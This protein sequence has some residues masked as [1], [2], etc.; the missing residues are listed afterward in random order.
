MVDEPIEI[1]V[2]GDTVG[3]RGSGA[4]RGA[5]R[6]VRAGDGH[7]A[8]H[9][10]APPSPTSSR[11][12]W[13]TTA[14]LTFVTLAEWE[15]DAVHLSHHHLKIG[16]DATVKHIS[17]TFGGDLVRIERVRGYDGP[18][19]DLDLLGLYSPTSGQHLEHRLFVDHAVPHCKSRALY[20]G[21]LQGRK[22]H[23]VW[24]GDVLIRTAAEGTDTYEMNRNLVLTEGARADSVPNLEIE[25]GEIVG[26][27]HASATGK[28][29]RRAA[30]LPAVPGHPAE[31]AKRLVVR[32]FFG[33]VLLRIG[34]PRWSSGPPRSSNG[35]SPSPACRRSGIHRPAPCPRTEGAARPTRSLDQDRSVGTYWSRKTWRHWI[36]ATCTSRSLT[37]EAPVEILRGVDLTVSSNETHAIMGPN[38]SGK[39]TL[40]YS[41]AGH[42]K[43]KVTRGSV[44][45][46]GQDLLAMT[47][48]E[49]ARAGL[50]LAMQ[51]PVEVP[52]VSTS[53]F[54]RTAAT[55]VRGQAPAIRTWVKEVK[56]AMNDLEID[57]EFAE[58]SVNEGFSGG[59]KKRHEILQ[60]TLLRPK[61]AILDETD[62]GLDVDALRVV[63]EG[64]NRYKAS[65]AEGGEGVGIMLITHY[66][67]ILRY[68]HP[69]RV[70][71]FAGGRIVE[72][73]GPELADELET[74]G[75]VR[76][77]GTPVARRLIP[78][79]TPAAP[80]RPETR[81]GTSDD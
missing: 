60:L 9:G 67:R 80:A 41:L 20:K 55:A 40:A 74:S 76:F 46:D 37:D 38:G 42:P 45:L 10:A 6:A 33:E 72:S 49:R 65:P 28:V 57:P 52:G 31:V 21:A 1:T 73:G 16:R 54:L 81:N 66:T 64:V 2:D 62:S 11:S 12:W 70:H 39:S 13:G 4:P 63:A 8:L 77:T 14:K 75:Y 69:D 27:G 17:L 26:A 3:A 47:V 35:N 5:A 59:E 71:V 22:A 18:G 53:N 23:T 50:F 19:G 58:R 7:P 36:S 68:I 78:R 30:V 61:I 51:Y 32:G 79:R 15:D 44:T 56:T 43:Y 48:D 25:T 34:I 24:V 29:R